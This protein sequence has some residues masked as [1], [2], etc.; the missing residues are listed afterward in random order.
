MTPDQ[1][2]LVFVPLALAAFVALVV[3]IMSYI[4]PT[5]LLALGYLAFSALWG[6]ILIAATKPESKLDNPEVTSPAVALAILAAT[7]GFVG[8]VYA[9]VEYWIMR[10]H[11]ASL[12]TLMHYTMASAI[13]ILVAKMVK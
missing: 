6:A 12:L 1:R 11:A 2:T 4:G 5:G 13:I 7:V 3:G 10:Q 9:F 8:G